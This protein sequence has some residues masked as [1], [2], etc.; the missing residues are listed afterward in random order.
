MAVFFVLVALML[1]GALAFVLPPL[2]RARGG[3]DPAQETRRKLRALEQARADGVLT[4][5]EYS[6]KRQ[7]LGEQ[8]LLVV[9]TPPQRPRTFGVALGVAL[10]LPALAIVLYRIVG[11]PAAL[12]AG[13]LAA[14]DAPAG[15]QQNMDQAIAGL[16]QKLKEH[17]E[18]AEGWALLGRAY[19]AMQRFAEARD[20]LKH[21]HDLSPE[22]PDVDVAYAEALAVASDSHRIDGESRSLLEAALKAAPDNQRGLWLL[23]ISDYQ[24]KQYDAAIA[25]WQHLLKVLPDGAP[26][27]RS[28]KHQIAS[29][30]AA[31]DGRPPPPDED[32]GEEGAETA[33][34]DAAAPAQTAP[35]APAAAAANAPGPHL[36][37]KVALDAKL[38]SKLAPDDVLYVYAKAAAGPP[39]PLAIQR[40]KASDL[41]TTVVLTDG[42]GMMPSLKLSQFPQVVVGARVSKSGNAIAQSGDLQ[43][44]SAPLAV[45]TSTPID[46]TIDHVVP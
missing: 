39:M 38:K 24:A 30:E 28:I 7:A 5:A 4:D 1:A 14:S 43:T 15:H 45:T 19:E 12:D 44:V 31:R 27:A 3:A 29:A 9:D 41:P 6:N 33:S 8:L 20:A 13:A 11:T 23:G 22:N 17:P 34:N 36:T 32:T 37:V 35:A 21:A 10:A 26:V 18:D 40:L 42:M 25:D 2:L 46:L 16:E